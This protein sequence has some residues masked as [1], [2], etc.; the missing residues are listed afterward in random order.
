MKHKRLLKCVQFLACLLFALQC[1]SLYGAEAQPL[2]EGAQLPR[3]TLPAPDSQQAQNYLGL[4][5]MEP[6]TLSQIDSKL[7]LIEFLSALCPHCHSNAPVVNRLYKVIQ[8]DAALARDVKVMGI[9]VG[10]SRKETDAYKKNC[11]VPFPVFPDQDFDIGAAV[12]LRETPVT[13]VVSNTGKVLMSYRG[14]I[15]NF[16]GFLKELRQSHKKQ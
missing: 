15:Q 11:K 6:F 1:C 4:K 10:S 13:V 7:F 9:A 2:S 3:F 12:E 5:T 14:V 8:E 16:D